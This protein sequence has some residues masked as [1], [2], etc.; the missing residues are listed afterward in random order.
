VVFVQ[1]T[2]LLAPAFDPVKRVLV[3]DARPLVEQISLADE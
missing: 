1:G 3:G 2:A